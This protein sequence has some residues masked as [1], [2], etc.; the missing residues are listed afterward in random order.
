MNDGDPA[1]TLRPAREEDAATLS[2]VLTEA[3]VAG[4]GE[5]LGVERIRSAT[6]G[7]VHPA[8]VVAERT[9]AV[10]G[11]VAWDDETG[12]IKR[13]FVLPEAW[14]TGIGTALLDHAIA[15]LRAAGVAQAWLNTE[16]RSA[17]IGFYE[18]R[19]WRREGE[20]RIRDW[21]GAHLEEPRFVLD[22]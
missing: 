17:A 22:L 2:E 8:D 3:G 10:V 6:A 14:G 7:R 11:F 15:A 20:P 5:F 9:G 21:H 18:S 16:E 13:L 12:E 1:W 19:G 4:W